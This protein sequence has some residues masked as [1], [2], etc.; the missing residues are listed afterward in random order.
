MVDGYWES[1]KG[2]VRSEKVLYFQME[3]RDT[4]ERR[5]GHCSSIQVKSPPSDT[6]GI[7]GPETRCKGTLTLFYLCGSVKPEDTDQELTKS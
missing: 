3:S 1:T 5:D 7:T 4:L 2:S 6:S